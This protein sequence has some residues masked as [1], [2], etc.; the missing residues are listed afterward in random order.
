MS[1][2]LNLADMLRRPLG[3]TIALVP[4]T[5]FLCVGCNCLFTF[6]GGMA[7]AP[8]NTSSPANPYLIPSFCFL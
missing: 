8:L 3:Y 5:G 7:E 1:L 2:K 4:G 6:V